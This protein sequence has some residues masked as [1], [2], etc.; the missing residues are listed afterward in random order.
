[1]RAWKPGGDVKFSTA[2]AERDASVLRSSYRP[3]TPAPDSFSFPRAQR[4]TRGPELERVRQQGKRIRTASLEARVTAS[5]RASEDVNA[6]D[7]VPAR[8]GF[9][10][11]RYRQTAVARNKLKRRL[12]ELVRIELLP[13]LSGVD[14]VIRVAPH[15]YQRDFD[16]LR[17]EV[18]QLKVRLVDFT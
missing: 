15:A 4:L 14:V 11:P 2:V 12:R 7:D 8:I 10:V 6:T 13:V 1:M 5:L 18:R 3:S 16:S 17:K 9:I